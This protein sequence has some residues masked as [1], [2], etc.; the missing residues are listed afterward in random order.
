ME[1]SMAGKGA[2]STGA[3]TIAVVVKSR[4]EPEQPTSDHFQEVG[5]DRNDSP[6]FMRSRFR[7]CSSNLPN[8]PEQ[9]Q[10]KKWPDAFDL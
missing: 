2:A 4:T 1:R 5:S 3:P 6:E 10:S 7:S 8:P 9:K